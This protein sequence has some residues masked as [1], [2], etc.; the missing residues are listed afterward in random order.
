VTVKI[1][2]VAGR[3]ALVDADGCALYVNTQD[4]PQISACDQACRAAFPPT[5]GPAQAGPGVAQSNLGTFT[6]ANGAIQATFF[7]HQLYYDA[8]D[9]Q[10]GQAKGQGVNRAWFLIDRNG[11][12]LTN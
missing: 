7:G 2:Q 9:T 5:P 11:T 8:H 10:P 4:T 1:A 12:T 3:E 6:R